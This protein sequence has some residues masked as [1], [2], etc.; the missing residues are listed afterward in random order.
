[1]EEYLDAGVPV[2]RQLADQLLLPLA[3]AKGG[4]FR[5]LPLTLHAQTQLELLQELYGTSFRV[6]EQ[7][8]TVE[9]AVA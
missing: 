5:T 6:T 2:G 1:V 7:G 8:S 3:L 9:I 4:A